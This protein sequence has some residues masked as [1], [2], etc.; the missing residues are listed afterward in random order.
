MALERITKARVGISSLGTHVGRADTLNF[1]GVGNTFLDHTNGQV[2]IGIAGGGGGGGLTSSDSVSNLLFIHYGEF[3]SSKTLKKPQKFG[4]IFTHEDST[5][6]ID[7]GVTVDIN[8]DCLL[9][10]TDKTDFDMNFFADPVAGTNLMR[11]TGAFDQNISCVFTSSVVLG[12][13]YDKVGYSQIPTE[14]S[15]D[16]SMDIETGVTIDVEDGAVMVL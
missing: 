7:N 10:T 8:E 4:E 5:I 14:L 1:V 6:D 9:L 15:D 12:S 16:L 13:G 2:D 11:S 3:P